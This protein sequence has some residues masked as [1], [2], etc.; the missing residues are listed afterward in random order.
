[1]ERPKG[2]ILGFGGQAPN[3]IAMS[4]YRAK[5]PTEVVPDGRMT[6]FGTSP[7]MIDHA[8]DRYKFSRALDELEVRKKTTKTANKEKGDSK[9]EKPP[10]GPLFV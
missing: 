2:L 5:F 8:E 6:I 4:L 10:S 1:M 9:K 7:E 3:N